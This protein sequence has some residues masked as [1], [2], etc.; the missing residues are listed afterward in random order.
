[1]LRLT[2]R[3]IPRRDEFLP[4][5]PI[6]AKEFQGVTMKRILFPGILRCMAILAVLIIP[7]TMVAS[8]TW[9]VTLG[10]QSED[11]SRQAMAF[12]PNE[13]WIHAGDNI[14]WTS[15][16]GESHTVMFLTQTTTGAAAP[17][18]TRPANGTAGATGCAGDAQGGT[19]TTPSPASLVVTN[20]VT[21]CINSGPICDPVFNRPPCRATATAGQ[22]VQP[23][24]LRRATPWLSRVVG[25]SSLYV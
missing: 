18:T 14:T 24:P 4:T 15:K 12:L 19:S 20:G 3:E 25:T 2:D 8:Q 1:M 7:K 6:F 10:A 23:I 16:S 22:T 17:G 11:A 9:Q 5:K 13:L 21:N